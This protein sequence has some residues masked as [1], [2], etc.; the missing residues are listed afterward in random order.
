MLQISNKLALTV[1]LTLLLSHAALSLHE[2]THV[3]SDDVECELCS[4]YAD[5]SDVVVSHSADWIRP[6]SDRVSDQA[7]SSA[8]GK[9]T[10]RSAFYPRGP[11]IFN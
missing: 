2:S 11:P 3:S 9:D 5:T 4:G 6:A 10:L 8:A 7:G 1:L